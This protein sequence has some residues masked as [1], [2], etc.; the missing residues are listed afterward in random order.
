MAVYPVKMIKDENGQPFVPITGANAIV[1]DDAETLQQKLDKKLEK[2]NIIAGAN[3]TL[4][5][6]G[7]NITISSGATGVL[8]DNL[9]TTT[10]GQGALDARQGSVLKGMIPTVINDVT[11]TSTTAALSAYQGYL[12]NNSKQATLVSGT[13]IKTINGQSLL[14][15]GSVT[16]YDGYLSWGGT[17]LSG[18]VSPVDA[19]IEPL[20]GGNKMAFASAAS[21]KIEYSTDGGNTWTDYG[22]ADVDK[23]K[24]TSVEGGYT[25][26]LGKGSSTD[27]SKNQL[28]ITL[29]ANAAGGNTYTSL[30]K[31]LLN[32]STNGATGTKVLVTYRTIGNYINSVDT[33]GTVGTYNLSGWSGWNSIPYN[34][35]FGGSTSQTSQTAQ[36]RLTFSQTGGTNN[37]NI[38]NIRM[39]G[40]TNWTT[41]STMART[42]H[43]YSYDVDQN[44][45][46]PGQVTA[47]QFNGNATSA[48]KAT[49]DGNGA[50]IASTYLKLAGGTMTGQIIYNDTAGS[51][52]LRIGSANKDT[53]IFRVYSSDQTYAETGAY[54][55]NLKYMGTGSEDANKLVLYADNQASTTQVAALTVTQA[56]IMT[57]KNNVN[58]AGVFIQSSTPTAVQTGDIWF[59]T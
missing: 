53:N 55:F 44:A 29:N 34:T 57:K 58:I 3:I 26:T 30:R 13:N 24:I 20:I 27:Y 8:I 14:G 41:P 43:L 10:A 1:Y 18:S 19:A 37:M 25:T 33:W 6:S 39:I 9:T 4:S 5:K 38:L 52:F 56:G 48:T 45:T 12:L 35:A 54:G 23:R 22:A 49:Q 21:F 31:I 28:R 7:N 17:N 46:F 16:T 42:G 11:S 32:V 50:N 2:D 15:S 36:I 40:I 51:T 59:V 47:T